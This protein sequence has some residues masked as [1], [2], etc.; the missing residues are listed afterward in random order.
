MADNGTVLGGV[1]EAFK[2]EGKKIVKE[3]GKQLAGSV[4][5]L[6]GLD[7]INPSEVADKSKQYEAEK[8]AKLAK[9]RS[10]L[11]MMEE[12]KGKPQ[13]DRRIEQGT[14]KVE[15]SQ[16]NQNAQMNNPGGQQ[17]SASQTPKKKIEPLVVQQKRNNKLHGAG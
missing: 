4:N 10:G 11:S 3:T 1:L 8:K 14:E 13:E 2:E 9:V 12:F 5:I 17:L 7:P 15:K 6:E 16:I